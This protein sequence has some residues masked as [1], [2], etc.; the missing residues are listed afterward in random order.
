VNPE[1]IRAVVWKDWSE[2]ARERALVV[3]TVAVPRLLVGIFLFIA[4][5]VPAL[6]DLT[7]DPDLAP[8]LERALRDDP[9]LAALGIADAAQVLLTR[10]AVVLLLVIPVFTTMSVASHAIVGEKRARTLEP[11]L[12]TPVT[13][14]EILAAK[15][16]AAG[17]PG[18]LL[19]WGCCALAGLGLFLLASGDVVRAVATPT[20]LILV[21]LGTPAVGLLGL[22]LAVAASTRARDAR[23]AQQ[24]GV[25]VILPIVGL[26]VGQVR[27][28]YALTP[29]AAALGAVGALVLAGLVLKAGVGLFDR[30]TI[31]TRWR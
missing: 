6:E 2:L 31:L 11:V 12:A 15:T 23:S 10:Q 4:A 22:S 25:V 19:A 13:T 3:T 16:L 21:V 27:G 1:R 20:T 26:L 17:I 29:A 18:I 24:V 28:V 7:R 30:E 8:L 9:G 5:F 14:M